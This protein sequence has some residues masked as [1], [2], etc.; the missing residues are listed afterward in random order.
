[1]ISASAALSR[2][3]GPRWL[4]VMKLPCAAA[5]TLL[6]VVSITARASI[7]VSP[8]GNDARSGASP[9]DA[10]LTLDRARDLVRQQNSHLTAD[11]AV[12]LADGTYALDHTWV[13]GPDDS[14]SGGHRVIYQAADGAHPVIS[15]GRRVTHW[16]E[17][18]PARH[19]WSAEVPGSLSN[20]RQLYVN[21]VRAFRA[22]G[23][24]PVQLKKTKEGYDADA[25]TMAAWRNPS[26]IEF[27]YTGGNAVWSEASSG[28]GPW[29]EPRCPIGEIAGS[30]IIMAQP[31]WANCTERVTNPQF[32]ARPANL[33]GPGSV[34]KVPEYVENAYELLGTP[35][36]WYLDRPAHR[37]YYVPRAG[38]DLNSAEVVI[39]VLETLLSGAGTFEH[40]VHDLAFNGLQFSYAT[41]LFPSSGEGF[42]E[43][44]ANYCITGPDGYKRQGLGEF[45]PGGSEPFGDWTPIAGNVAFKAAQRVEFSGDIFAHL[46]GA[47]LALGHG[48]QNCAVV[49]SVFTDISGNG[50]N[51]GGVDLP[52]ATGPQATRDDRIANNHFFNIAAEYHGGIAIVTGYAQRV[53]VEHNQIDHVPYS[54]ISMGWGGWPDKAKRPG[55]ANTSQNNRIA[56]NLIFDHMLLLADGAA[57]YTQGLTGPNLAK[58]EK[59][60]GN[61]VYNQFGSGHGIYSD[62]G[63]CYMTITG[64]VMF[65]T[66]HDNWGS[67]HAF[68]YDGA[69]GRTHD[70]IIVKDN[71][72]QQGDPD[73]D[74]QGVVTA[75]NRLI[76]E[77]GQVPPG[78]LA[79]AGVQP[80]FRSVLSVVGGPLAPPEPPSRVAVAAGNR[81]LLVTWDPPCFEGGT[82][83]LSYTVTASTGQRTTVSAGDFATQ[84]FARVADV[85]NGQ[86]VNVQV[87]ANNAQGASVP[88]LPSW[89][90]RGSD[91]KVKPPGAPQHVHVY[92][93]GDRA[94]VH[95]QGPTSDGG[96]PIVA[97]FVTVQP[98][99]RQVVL[100]GRSVVVLGLT[101]KSGRGHAIFEVVDGLP[102]TGPTGWEISAV[103]VAGPGQAAKLEP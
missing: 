79:A 63:S 93:S 28:L 98:G 15:G 42:P 6:S 71:Y 26:D 24:I 32:K 102:A 100:T 8:S 12:I 70:P 96:A 34:G 92:R 56:Q 64:N 47:G 23:R 7:Y 11:L 30:R 97:Y 74:N 3:S 44:Q 58:G 21:G 29:T 91:A 80:A 84:A 14:G 62:N 20:S 5:L 53:V 46:G 38:E 10:V 17:I 13:L 66:N 37:V 57:I 49:G 48:T 4:V 50:I 77:L 65:H 18:D 1:M 33:V 68:Y 35:G 52:Q 2:R 103:N 55:V 95:F 51:L 39:P 99:N 36:Q 90:V 19:L 9:A 27:V 31:G 43:I 69:D 83:V 94:S 72:W 85:P 87:V 81:T 73:R 75:H 54:G 61:V 101:A 16:R 88:S 59:V 82:P 89:P 78:V 67:A 60:T 25:P 86:P 40:P 45:Y 22:R 76:S 41:W